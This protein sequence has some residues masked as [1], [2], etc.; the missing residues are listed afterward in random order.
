MKL[1]IDECLPRKLKFVFAAGG[2]E[3]ET[4]RDA[5]F[6]SKTN[7]ELLALAEGKFDVF[8]TIDRNIRYQQNLT[9]RTIAVLILCA[10]SNDVGHLS[11]LVPSALAAL[12]SIQSG[13]VIEVGATE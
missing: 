3:C 5:G 9:G 8:I 6:G 1:L 10:Y 11:P 12:R 4:V 7:G 13:Q 2:H